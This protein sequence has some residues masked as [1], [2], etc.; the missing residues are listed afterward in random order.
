VPI[1]EGWVRLRVLWAGLVAGRFEGMDED[2]NSEEQLM[3]QVWAAPS[4]P[5]AVVRWW[6][7]WVL[8]PPS[9]LSPDG[10]RQIEGLEAVLDR[11]NRL[12]TLTYRMTF[13]H[14][15]PM[16]GGGQTSSVYAVLFDP[17]SETWWV[18][19]SDIR[20]TL[21]EITQEEAQDLMSRDPAP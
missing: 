17:E 13:R 5:S 9:D 15:G 20:R 1:D 19:G 3:F 10:R 16:P 11:L 6:S 4:S 2:G 12:R 14:S 21:R 18:D 8:P 7:E